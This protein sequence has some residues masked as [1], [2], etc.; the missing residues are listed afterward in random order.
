[1]RMRELGGGLDLAQEAV[2]AQRNR[3][4]GTEDLDGD[5]PVM[6][7]IAGEIDRGHPALAQLALDGVAVRQG[8]RQAGEIVRQKL[9]STPSRAAIGA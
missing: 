7:E 9:I 1:V 5:R 8:G 4:L 3:Q 6:L 2:G